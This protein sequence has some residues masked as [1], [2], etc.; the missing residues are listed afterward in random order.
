[1]INVTYTGNYLLFYDRISMSIYIYIYSF[2]FFS[3][4]LLIYEG[5]MIPTRSDDD[6]DEPDIIGM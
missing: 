6:D 5:Q 2:S 3:S 4:F 1:M